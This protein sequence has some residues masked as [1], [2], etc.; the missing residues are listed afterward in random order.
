M[1]T[2]TIVTGIEQPPFGF[3]P[4]GASLVEE[5]QRGYLE[6]VGHIVFTVRPGY[7]E[8][9]AGLREVH[10]P[11][12]KLPRAE[13]YRIALPF[14]PLTQRGLL[15]WLESIRPDMLYLHGPYQ[16]ASNLAIIAKKLAIPYILHIHTHISGYVESRVPEVLWPVAKKLALDRAKRL[17][18]GAAMTI[19][20]S[21]TYRDVFNAETSFAGP[22]IVFPSFIKPFQLMPEDEKKRFSFFFRKGHLPVD[23][24]A[25]PGIV[26][27]SRLEKE[28][29]PIYPMLCFIELLKL[30]DECPINKVVH[31]VLIYVGGGTQSCKQELVQLARENGILDKVYFVGSQGNEEAKKILQTANQSWFLSDKDTQGIVPFEAGFA[32]VPVFGLAGQPFDEFFGKKDFLTVSRADPFILAVRSHALLAN[33]QKRIEMAQHCQSVAVAYSDTE[34]Y[35]N[36]FLRICDNIIVGTDC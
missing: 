16:V 14:D 6:E 32:E 13:N 20:P 1:K 10:L 22:S 11:S 19:F 23:P 3:R 4:N 12:I 24:I 2:Y 25:Y 27:H 33:E 15:S 18:S 29:N 17:A 8:I 35:K 34:K 7:P 26:V 21:E 31:P 28:K 9:K 30:L 5:D 36:D